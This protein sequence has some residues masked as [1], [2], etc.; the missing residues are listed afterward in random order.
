MALP[1]GFDGTTDSEAA[2]APLENAPL[3]IVVLRFHHLLTVARQQAACAGLADRDAQDC[4]LMFAVRVLRKRGCAPQPEAWLC[5]CALNYAKNFRRTIT[6]RQSHEQGWPGAVDRE[7]SHP[8]WDCADSAPLLESG[9]LR[10][11]FWQQ[12]EA[13]IAQL[14]PAPRELFIRHH[15]CGESIHSLATSTGRTVPAIKQALLRARRRLR[16]VLERDGM[17]EEAA[18]DYLALLLPP[19]GDASAPARRTL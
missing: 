10:I 3:E 7:G 4:A 17:G 18:R 12:V 8:L 5:R 14:E 13:A 15:L 16:A 6:R 2:N 19:A 1:D 9:L 11:E